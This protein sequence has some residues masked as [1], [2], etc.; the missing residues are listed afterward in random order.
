MQSLSR[1][2]PPTR[3]YEATK[4]HEVDNSKGNIDMF[5]VMPPSTKLCLL[6][7]SHLGS[8]AVE[9]QQ[10]IKSLLKEKL[11]CVFEGIAKAGHPQPLNDIYIEL[12]ITERGSGEV[13]K[14]HEVT[15]IEK[16]SRTPVQEQ[17]PIR[18]GDIFK[19]IGRAHV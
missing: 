12:F 5:P 7:F 14:E 10:K 16:A 18:C 8:A 4:Y 13:N 11:R 15:L 19:Q 6:L 3:S 2:A 1:P 17:T 9:C